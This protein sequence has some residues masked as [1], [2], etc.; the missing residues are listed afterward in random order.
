M[1]EVLQTGSC[2]TFG[3][4]LRALLGYINDIRLRPLNADSGE[5]SLQ[6]N[7]HALKCLNKN[8]SEESCALDLRIRDLRL[9]DVNFH[10]SNVYS[11]LVR[12]NSVLLSLDP[13]KAIVMSDR[14]IIVVSPQRKTEENM[15]H[16]LRIFENHFKGML[17]LWN[18]FLFQFF[19]SILLLLEFHFIPSSSCLPKLRMEM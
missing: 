3:K 8:Y 15:D 17:L 13:F 7:N 2:S 14:I 4:S 19:F 5:E 1:R 9:L 16:I 11:I 18:R 6:A 12:K 10:P